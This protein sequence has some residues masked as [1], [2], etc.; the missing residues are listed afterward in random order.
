MKA[1]N[2][3]YPPRHVNTLIKKTSLPIGVNI[4]KPPQLHGKTFPLGIDLNND[5]PLL[6]SH[7]SMQP[8]EKK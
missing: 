3:I 2:A 5:H 1:L 8:H 6:E 7:L 4:Q